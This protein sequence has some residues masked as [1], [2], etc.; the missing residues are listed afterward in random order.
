MTLDEAIK[1]AEEVA[2]EE[3]VNYQECVAVLDMEGAEECY[4]CGKQ[5]EQLAVWLK[6][7]KQLREQSKWIPIVR[8][9]PTEEEKEEYFEQH[10]EE[11]CY[12]ID[13]QMPHN[14]QEVLLSGGD[15]VAED[16][17]MEDFW[18]FENWDIDNVEAWMP[19]PNPYNAEME[20][21]NEAD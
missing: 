6:E 15:T 7:L 14:G 5:H 13:N 11:L 17:F 19:L 8:R 20:L 1:H 2:L 12:M 21:Y 3:R 16:I 4:E 10:R 18:N 9:E